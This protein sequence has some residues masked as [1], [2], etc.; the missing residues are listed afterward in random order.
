MYVLYKSER[1][2]ES[3]GLLLVRG[4]DTYWSR[5]TNSLLSC[6]A[7]TIVRFFFFSVAFKVNDENI[8]ASL[9]AIANFN[10]SE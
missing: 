5:L 7:E 8:L 6:I 1:I 3:K 9:K 2:A 10:K 4:K